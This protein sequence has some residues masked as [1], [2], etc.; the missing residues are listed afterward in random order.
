MTNSSSR[1]EAVAVQIVALAAIVAA[2]ACAGFG[3][4]LVAV[5]SSAVV[6][7]SPATLVSFHW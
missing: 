3:L 5:A 4:P 6:G 7:L 1:F 2:G